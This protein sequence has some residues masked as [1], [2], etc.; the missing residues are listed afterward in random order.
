MLL[1]YGTRR[2]KPDTALGYESRL[3]DLEHGTPNS[4]PLHY[5]YELPHPAKLS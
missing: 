2:K 1:F 5:P 3:A 4:G